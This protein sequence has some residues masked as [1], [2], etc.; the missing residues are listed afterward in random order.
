MAVLGLC[1]PYRKL[2][3]NTWGADVIPSPSE[4]TEAGR[5][6]LSE[7]PN[8][9]GSLGIAVSEAIPAKFEPPPKQPITTSGSAPAFSI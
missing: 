9:S 8:S 6:I 1:D 7:H 4:L 3:M 5:K 2:M